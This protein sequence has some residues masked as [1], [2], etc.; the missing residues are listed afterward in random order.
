MELLLL[1]GLPGSGKSTLAKV[2]AKNSSAPVFGVDDFFT[3]PISGIY[4][5][6]YKRNYLAYQHCQQRTEAAMRQHEK[7]IVLDNTST[8]EWEMEPYF[9]LAQKYGYR[10]HVVTVEHWHNGKNV[11]QITDEQLHKMAAKYQVKLI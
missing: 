6:D 11:H 5:F 7:L 4:H 2:L 3:D 1:R 8:E 9:A 10:V